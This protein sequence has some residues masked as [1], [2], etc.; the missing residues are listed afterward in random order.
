MDQHTANS[1]LI[2]IA[3][4]EHAIAYRRGDPY[5]DHFAQLGRYSEHIGNFILEEIKKTPNPVVL[6]LGANI[7][8]TSLFIANSHPEVSLV[9]LEPSPETILFLLQ[10]THNTP[11]I[12]TLPL[13]VGAANSTV[14]FASSRTSA[15]GS[16]CLKETAPQLPGI[17]IEGEISIPCLTL[18]HIVH[19]LQITSIAIIKVDVE[20]SEENVLLG[21]RKILE[22]LDPIWVIEFNPWV[23]TNIRNKSPE[24]FLR[25]L[26]ALFGFVESLSRRSRGEVSLITLDVVS[27]YLASLKPDEVDDLICRVQK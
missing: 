12:R 21:A 14:R 27:T 18:D 3:G 2:S 11:N 6:D 1:A 8:L 9:A 17:C 4:R 26:L 5:G 16:F 7:G 13:A 10:N 23:I 19:A 15:S 24:A 20:G 25:Y 22:S